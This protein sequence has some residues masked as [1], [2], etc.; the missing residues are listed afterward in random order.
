MERPCCDATDVHNPNETS[1]RIL[2]VIAPDAPPLVAAY[3]ARRD[4]LARFF[5]ARLGDSAEVEDFLQE[6][7][8]KVAVAEVGA[9]V[10]NLGGY[11]FR[12]ASN[13]LTDRW[14]SR[15]QSVSRDHAWRLANYTTGPVED[16][17]DAPSADK[18]VEHRQKLALLMAELERLPRR[19]QQIFRMHKFDGVTYA[20]VAVALGISQSSVEKHMSDPLQALAAKVRP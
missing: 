2:D 13:L 6:L 16:I 4:S 15:V 19:T 12:L 14:R 10:E 20:G 18:V 5:R 1:A 8:L 7:Y 11:L 17:D 9:E 3:F